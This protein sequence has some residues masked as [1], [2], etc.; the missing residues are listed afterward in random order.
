[1]RI[2]S[3]RRKFLHRMVIL[4]I[5]IVV[6]NMLTLRYLVSNDIDNID[7][8]HLTGRA[9][10]IDPGHGGIDGGAAYNGLSEKDVTLSI[11]AKLGTILQNNGATVTYTRDSDMD[12]YTK[13]K[14]GKRNDLTKRVQ[15]IESSGAEVFISIH[16]NA[17][18]GERWFGSQVFYN[19]KNEQNK[20]L[21]E[22]VQLALKEYSPGN[23]R[24]A[25]QDTQIF[26][27]NSINIP[28]VLVETGYLS[29]Q[30]E[31]KFLAD[32]NYQQKLA[33]QIAK[34]LAYH[35]SNNEGR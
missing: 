6:L 2:L 30:R 20:K 10:I 16:C 1:M 29:N 27:L 5:A 24:Q 35:F 13:G 19:N 33:E 17:I 11:S 8:G 3:M 18:K 14:G 23:K 28:G 12:Y 21:A 9:V 7:L 22:V 15:L 4:S 26:L 34:A 25:K 31:A 32:E